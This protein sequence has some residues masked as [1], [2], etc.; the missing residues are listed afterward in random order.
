M[1][2]R[3]WI[4]SLA[5]L[6]AVAAG[7][8]ARG[9]EKTEPA[10]PKAT[11][12]DVVAE[13]VKTVLDT[14]EVDADFTQATT[15]LERLFQRVAIHAPSNEPAAFVE[16]AFARRLVSQLGTMSSAKQAGTL[17]K[18]LRA[19]R[20][21][22]RALAFAVKADRERPEPIYQLLDKLR[23]AHGEKLND[24]AYLAAAVCVVHDRP[25]S[26]RINEN[27]V[28]APD[29]I[30][31]FRYFAGHERKMLFGIKSVPPELLVYVVDTTA[32]IKEMRWALSRY[33]GETKV[34]K[35]FFK[36]KYDY[37]HYRTGAKKKVT[38]AGF[39]LPN[40]LRFG[41]V[42]ADQAYFAVAIGKAIGVP[43]CYAVGRSG[44]SGH[45]WVG[46]FQ[47]RKGQ[48]R[49]NFEYGRYAQYTVVRGT[50][51][52][53]QTRQRIGDDHLSVQ[54][55]LIGAKAAD[56]YA[57]IAFADAAGAL[58]S[59]A[60]F[61]EAADLKPLV[62]ADPA[63]P[64]KT[65]L[66]AQLD[67]IEQGLRR[68]PGYAAGWVKVSE[69]A[70]L[71]E[72]TLKQKKYWAGQLQ[73][74]C[75]KKYPDFSMAVIKPMIETVDDV[76]EQNAL[77]NACFRFFSKRKDLAAEI[78][79]AQAAMWEEAG[80]LAKAGK[81]Y[82]DVITR[83]INSG[84]FAIAALT[85]VERKLRELN[86]DSRVAPLYALAWSKCRKPVGM[87][88]TFIRAANWTRVGVLYVR[89]LEAAGQTKKAQKVRAAIES[90]VGKL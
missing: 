30:D 78:R 50:V 70:R 58:A 26:R 74:M 71:G 56:R 38:A 52:D 39:N 14:L 47:A 89:A 28:E 81:C 60:D 36:I 37:R 10:E 29:P 44:Q 67:L 61:G 72:M 33:K 46:F 68:A 48:G 51:L 82:E 32:S 9:A 45:A 66:P 64:R 40:I 17:L 15:T 11:C 43:T 55:E 2:P 20:K 88:P 63:E 57:A 1:R 77:W 83:Y 19:N 18:Y 5:L 76:G 41:G 84:P 16:A 8:G 73:K 31:V 79:M 27:R 4:V 87:A 53:P 65:D 86:R 23:K 21:L 12:A 6:A 85:K 80:Q 22:A 54:A 7:P 75:G 90:V 3:R 34:G 49:W 25:L 59:V 13:Q 35:H 69:M 62:S 42:C 24:Y